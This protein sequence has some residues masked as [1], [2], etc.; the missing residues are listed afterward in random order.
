MSLDRPLSIQA[1][2]EVLLRTTPEPCIVLSSSTSSG[3]VG[4]HGH[5]VFLKAAQVLAVRPAT[6]F[7]ARAISSVFRQSAFALVNPSESESARVSLEILS[8]FSGET[9]GAAEIEIPPLNRLAKFTRELVPLP[10]H[11]SGFIRISSE[12]PIAV[13][14]LVMIKPDDLWVSLPV[15]A[16]TNDE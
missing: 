14:G 2:S 15:E 13:G 7:R 6:E 11:H 4:P 3:R 9:I 1:S 12:I 10:I 16:L 5:S 8:N